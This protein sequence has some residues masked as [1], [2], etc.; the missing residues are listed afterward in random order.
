MDMSVDTVEVA[1]RDQEAF[2][3]IHGRATFKIGPSLKQFGVMAVERGCRRFIVEMKNCVGMDSTF[4][5]ILAGL[6]TTLKK[7]EGDVVLRN[8][9]E[10]NLFLV[11]MLGLSHLITIDN[12]AQS[13]IAMPTSG[14]VL[15]HSPSDKKQMTETMIAAHETLVEAAPDNIIKFKDVLAYLKED[16][17][18][19][20]AQ[21][22]G[23]PVFPR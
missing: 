16:L 9:S 22:S 11:K 10:K 15:T 18:R 2:I 12:S 20:N 14:H 4:M 23:V 8:L 13:V 19:T 7:T 17:N 21:Q 1:I 5:G 6:A 3:R